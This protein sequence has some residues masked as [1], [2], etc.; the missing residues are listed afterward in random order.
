MTPNGDI[1]ILA[2]AAFLAAVESLR[3]ALVAVDFGQPAWPPVV[4]AKWSGEQT[5][6]QESRFTALVSG[7]DWSTANVKRSAAKAALRDT[8]DRILIAI[9]SALWVFHQSTVE[10]RQEFN[11]LL[12]DILAG[13]KPTGE[14]VSIRDWDQA[15]AAVEQR[16][17]AELTAAQSVNLRGGGS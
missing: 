14:L 13:Q 7:W 16:I 12:Q 9:R 1:Q 4:V 2:Q 10:L 8:D 3:P 11:R 17:D 15:V 6:K 5:R